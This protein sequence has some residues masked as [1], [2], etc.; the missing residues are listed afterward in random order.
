M[1]R[2]TFRTTKPRFPFKL[3]ARLGFVFPTFGCS[4][5]FKQSAYVLDAA[6]CSVAKDE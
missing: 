2:L 1:P 4:T 6:L 5:N 3:E